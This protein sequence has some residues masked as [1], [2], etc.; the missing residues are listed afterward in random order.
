MVHHTRDYL[1]FGPCPSTGIL[2]TQHF[3]IFFFSKF[4]Y[5]VSWKP[6]ISDVCVYVVIPN[7]FVEWFSLALSNEPNRVG[8]STWR[9]KQIL[10]PKRC[11]LQTTGRWTISKNAVTPMTHRYVSLFGI[12]SQR[13]RDVSLL[14]NFQF[15][16]NLTRRLFI[17]AVGR[18][19]EYISLRAREKEKDDSW[20]K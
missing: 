16:K 3:G 17:K 6:P 13:K 11:D 8:A 2:R 20:K 12:C 1:V 14:H 18:S 15:S 4:F 19:V 7:Q 10:F 9:R 5:Y